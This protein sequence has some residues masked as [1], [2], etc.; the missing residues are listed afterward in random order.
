MNRVLWAIQ[1][2]TKKNETDKLASRGWIL[3]E[4]EI[5]NTKGWIIG[6]VI[7]GIGIVL[8]MIAVHGANNINRRFETSMSGTTT[9]YTNEEIT[10]MCTDQLVK[11]GYNPPPQIAVNTC[12]GTV[13]QGLKWF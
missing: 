3:K 7:V 4:L 1:T 8:A 9:Q 10:Q 6:S 12:V 5:S 13:I 2:S 11:L